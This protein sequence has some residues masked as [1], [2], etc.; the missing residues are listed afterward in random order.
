MQNF[1]SNALREDGI[2]HICR[3]GIVFGYGG[4]GTRQEVFQAACVNHEQAD[5][6]NQ[7]PMAFLDSNFWK[8]N[9]IWDVISNTSI[10][11]PFHKDLLLT[12]DVDKI[13]TLF[14]D[15]AHRKRLCLTDNFDIWKEKH[16]MK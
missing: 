6:L 5:P 2:I 1:F 8:N 15:H 16:W 10:K 14:V 9:G 4:P 12:D 13:V 11:Q 7:C 3:A